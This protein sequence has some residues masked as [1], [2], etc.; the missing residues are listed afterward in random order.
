L[1]AEPGGTATGR[2]AGVVYAANTLGCVAGALAAP[3]L[4]IP[5]VGMAGTLGLAAS[6]LL[7]GALSFTWGDPGIPRV[8]RAGLAAALVAVPLLGWPTLDMRAL[9]AGVFFHVRHL[10]NALAPG[11]VL[12][13]RIGSGK[14]LFHRDGPAA[15]VTVEREDSSSGSRFLSVNGKPD[16]SSGADLPTQVLAAHLPWA[17]ATSGRYPV[18]R[19][20][21]VGLASGMTAGSLLR[22]PLDRLDVIEIEPA[23]REASRFFEDVNGW[24]LADPRCRLIVDDARHRLRLSPGA[25]DLVVSVPSNP[26][27]A[28]QALL[29]TKEAF[30]AGRSALAPGGVFAQW[31]QYYSLGTGDLRRILATFAAVFPDHACFSVPGFSDLFLVGSDRERRLDREAASAL[32]RTPAVREDL[33]R[34]RVH[35]EERV[36]DSLELTREEYGRFATGGGLNTDDNASVEFS[37]PRSLYV[38]TE[39]ANLEAIRSFRTRPLRG[40]PAASGREL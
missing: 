35:D 26:W 1:A 16:A 33:A 32:F 30:E 11:E 14:V 10:S 9:S 15:T 5:H 17:W 29:F 22:H 24:P 38:L 2:S 4:L 7:A 8:A 40:R 6:S 12:R 34:A 37:A 27:V 36:L 13:Q 18:R 25:Y 23:M 20:A 31:V 28:G 39:G 21:L 19:V 3:F